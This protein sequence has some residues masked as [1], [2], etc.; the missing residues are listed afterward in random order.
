VSGAI[1]GTLGQVTT[2]FPKDHGLKLIYGDR[3]S[4]RADGVEKE[5]G[6]LSYTAMLVAAIET[7]EAVKVL[8]NRGELL[9]NRLLIVD[10]MALSFDTVELI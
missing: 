9:R 1:A 4:T 10:L 7:S 2:I 6:N 5:M 8:L 3:T